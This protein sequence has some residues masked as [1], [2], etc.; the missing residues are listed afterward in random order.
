MV[1]DG[2]ESG[3]SIKDQEHSRRS[4]KAGQV[5]PDWQ[6]NTDTKNLGNQE[7]FLCNVNNKMALITQL[8]DYLQQHS[9]T[10][11]QHVMLIL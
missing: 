7:A 10:V 11:H 5:V 6:I 8:C 2:Y 1:F 9:I 3:P 4:L